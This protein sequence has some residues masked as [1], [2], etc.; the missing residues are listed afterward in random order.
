MNKSCFKSCITNRLQLPFNLMEKFMG[1]GPFSFRNRL[2]TMK[3]SQNIRQCSELV[4]LLYFIYISGT[5]RWTSKILFQF[6]KCTFPANL[7]AILSTATTKLCPFPNLT[8]QKLLTRL[9]QKILHFYK[10]SHRQ[11][12][13]YVNYLKDRNFCG[14]IFVILAINRENKFCSDYRL[15]KT[16]SG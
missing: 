2:Q 16:M 6:I 13:N 11:I 15:R 10:D 7:A 4:E 9:A 12:R 8:S 5:N 3:S 1:G 14:T